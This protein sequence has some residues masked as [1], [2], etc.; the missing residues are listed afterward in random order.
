M[1]DE[2]YEWADPEAVVMGCERCGATRPCLNLPDPYTAALWP[3][4]DNPPRWVCRS[5]HSDRREA[6]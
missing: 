4:D 3:E 6:I 2:K 5:C 1:I